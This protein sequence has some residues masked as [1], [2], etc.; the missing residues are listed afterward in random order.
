MQTNPFMII[1]LILMT[2]YVFIINQNWLTKI[3]INNII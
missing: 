3:V 1:S 2:F